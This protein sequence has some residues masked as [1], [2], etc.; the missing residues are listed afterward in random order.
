MRASWIKSIFGAASVEVR[1]PGGP[2]GEGAHGYLRTGLP[3]VASTP[4]RAMKTQNLAV[5]FTG[6]AD[7]TACT[8]AQTREENARMMRRHDALLVPVIRG[9]GGRGVKS[10]G[11][12]QAAFRGGRALRR[13]LQ[14]QRVGRDSG[15]GWR[16]GGR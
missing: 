9:S 14:W 2:G 16:R 11:G 3:A 15:L 6:I 7:F 10:V 5:M 4:G 8:S 12:R 1:P 13:R